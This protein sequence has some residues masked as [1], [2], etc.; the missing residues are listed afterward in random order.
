MKKSSL[1][2][3]YCRRRKQDP[4]RQKSLNPEMAELGLEVILPVGLREKVHLVCPLRL[5]PRQQFGGI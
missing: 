1:A 2:P 5:Q 4:D 3:S